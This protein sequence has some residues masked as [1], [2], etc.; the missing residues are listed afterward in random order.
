MDI[1]SWC[2][3]WYQYETGQLVVMK[4]DYA[5]PPADLAEFISAFY[6]FEG[7]DG[8]VDDIERAS[9]AQFRLTYSGEGAILYDGEAPQVIPPVSI[10][11]PRLRSS[12]IIGSGTKIK[13]FGFGILPAGWAISTGLG[14]DQFVNRV[15]PIE[16]V[17]G[18]AADTLVAQ[19]A[20]LDDLE[21]MVVTSVGLARA[22]FAEAK[23]GPL[24]FIRALNAWLESSLDPAV[25]DLAA[26]AGL[27]R[28][29]AERLAKKYCGAPPKYLARM[30]RAL[31]AANA[32]AND[33]QDWQ[34]FI[35]DAFYDQSHFI[36]EIKYFTGLTPS[37]V[38]DH[39]SR[40]TQL[41]FG[42]HQL[43]GAVSSLVADS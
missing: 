30:Y 16:T 14:A 7:D 25:E 11:G 4:L 24:T 15:V 1:G 34:D 38:R 2:C 3:V 40:L 32:I 18:S 42:R 23:S 36:R 27:S 6:L 39:H 13:V 12:R 19:L 28:R 29:Q 43:T 20:E 31:R 21:S 8:A 41:V 33:H 22:H 17:F 37:G 5:A 26:A 10:M 35:S 9:V